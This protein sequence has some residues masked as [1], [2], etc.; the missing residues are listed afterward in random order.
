MSVLLYVW[1]FSKVWRYIFASLFYSSLFFKKKFVLFS[2]WSFPRLG[3]IFLRPCSIPLCFL[4]KCLFYSL[5]GLFPR[6]GGIFLRPCSIPLCFLRKS[7]FYSLFGLF[8][9]WEVYFCVPVLFLFVS[10]ENVCSIL[11]LVG[12]FS[13]VGRY[14]FASLFYASL[15]HKK[16][17]VLL[18]VWFF[19][20]GCTIL[21][22]TWS[23]SMFFFRVWLKSVF[24]DPFAALYCNGKGHLDM[25]SR[26]FMVTTLRHSSHFCKYFRVFRLVSDLHIIA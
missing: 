14:I 22:M 10:Q 23:F 24:S 25:K 8:Q 3:G 12:S 21:R 11:C 4:R 16:M 17:C 1:S 18:S 6:L 19:F 13:K 26:C 9:G 2:V 15:L 5:S 20:Q 7:L